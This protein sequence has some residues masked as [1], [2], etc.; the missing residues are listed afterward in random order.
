MNAHPYRGASPR[1]TPALREERIA[2]KYLG[3]AVVNAQNIERRA[4][5]DALRR[6]VMRRKA[7]AILV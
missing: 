4:H 5:Y 1:T 3:D 7:R 6:E 2:R